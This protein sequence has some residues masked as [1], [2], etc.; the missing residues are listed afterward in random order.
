[1]EISPQNLLVQPLTIQDQ[2]FILN[3][4]LYPIENKD[5]AI[6][7]NNNLFSV[8]TQNV[9]DAMAYGQFDISNFEHG[10]VFNNFTLFNDVIYNLVTGLRQDRIFLRG[11]KSAEWNGTMYAGGFIL[12]QDNVQEWDPA[13]KYTRG[14][15]VLYKNNYYQAQVVVNPATQ[16][17]PSQWKLTN[18]EAIQ[19]GMLSNPSTRAY[20][21]TL[22][23]D[24][25][26]ANLHDDADTLGYSLIGYRPRDYLALL[27]LTNV[28]QVQVYQNLI[29]N[30]G[31][32]NSV[33]AF[34]GANLPT[35]GINYSV[36]EIWSILSGKFGG[37]LNNN[38]IDFS[39]NARDM[40][41]DPSIVS[42]T[43]GT[44]NTNGAMQEIPLNTLYNYGT[45]ISS[46]NFLPVT[47]NPS[48]NN[49]YPNAGFVNF[50]DITLASYYYAGLPRATNSSG[51]IVPIQ[52]FYVGQYAWLA[53]FMQ[54]WG[55]YSWEVVGQILQVRN[56]NNSTV[57]LTFSAPHNLA[58]LQSLSIVNFAS[59]VNGYY[60]VIDVPSIYEAVIN[61]NLNNTTQNSIQGLGIGL[62]FKSHRVTNPSDIGNL[63]LTQADFIDNLVW[64]DNNVDG[65][66]AVLLK[67]NNYVMQNTLLNQPV[68]TST[69]GSAVA[70]TPDIGY[71]VGDAAAGNVYRYVLNS[72]TQ[73][74]EIYQTIT[75]GTSFGSEISYSASNDIYVVS[76]PTGT[77]EVFIYTL[78]NSPLGDNLIQY[79]SAITAPGGVTN[80]GSAVAISGDANWI[81]ISD[82]TNNNI[83][84]YRRDNIPL[85]AGYFNTGQTYVITELGS[86]DFTA[87]GASYNACLL[88]TS[89][90]ADE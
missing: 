54:D 16:F 30:K 55:V 29:I 90:A 12:N 85:Q 23:Y 83:Y 49:T 28:A 72:L 61:L 58:R 24:I 60:I 50:N 74:Y 73:E 7:R 41:G 43:D 35:G 40:T 66:W 56:N 14:S 81:Y 45:P 34:E 31:T 84:V 47:S 67:A 76:Q 70:Y 37:T 20:E 9:G 17:N 10:I 51:A 18:Y 53:N 57:T 4:N 5:L 19:I 8:K 88:Y 82:I 65:N 48:V 44:I 13:V 39:I 22:F 42:L 79:Q 3:Q 62:T 64:V 46:P 38:F 59:N 6:F 89:D 80:W 68:S 71:L 27:D 1:M 75:N 15:V 32:L 69:F 26:Q 2:N 11:E 86:T 87:I 52:N 36:N 63:N 77:P 33:S 78:N 21:S 25:N